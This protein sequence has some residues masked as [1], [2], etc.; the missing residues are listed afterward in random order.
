[1]PVSVNVWENV[2]GPVCGPESH[3]P[4]GAF[5]IPDVIEWVIG[6]RVRPHTQLIV[7]PRRTWIVLGEKLHTVPIPKPQFAAEQPTVM[8]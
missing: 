7:S 3:L 6:V 4:S 2:N 1:M 8:V 5:T